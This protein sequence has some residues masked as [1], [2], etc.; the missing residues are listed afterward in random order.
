MDQLAKML[1]RRYNVSFIFKSDVLKKYRISGIIRKE[2]LE[3]VLDLL[4]LTVPMTYKIKEGIVTIDFD[5][6]RSINYLKTM[7]Y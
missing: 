4:K 5:K 3:Q 1:E 2:T 7:Q 6:E